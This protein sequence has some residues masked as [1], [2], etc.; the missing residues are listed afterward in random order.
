MIVVDSS[1]WVEY[2]RASGDP[3]DARLTELLERG[4]DVAITEVVFMEILAGAR[5][6]GHRRDLRS[7][8]LACPMLPLEGLADFEEAAAVYRV[9]RAAGETIRSMT[10]ILV[11]VPAIRED[12]SVLHK[13]RDF[14]AIARHTDLRI[15][16]A[17]GP[18]A[19]PHPRSGAR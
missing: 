4:E 10:D 11:A 18:R 19:S 6:R 7:A 5:S 13:D 15:E 9:C 14:D 12:A 16:R 3:V 1:A 2:L 8:L 17:G